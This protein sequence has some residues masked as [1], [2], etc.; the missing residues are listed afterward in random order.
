MLPIFMGEDLFYKL[1]QAV[2]EG[3]TFGRNNELVE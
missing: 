1:E 2:K 3:K